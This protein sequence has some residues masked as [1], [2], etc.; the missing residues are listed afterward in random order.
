MT[1]LSRAVDDGLLRPVVT[2]VLAMDGAAQAHRRLARGGVA[3]RI[4]LDLS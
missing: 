1:A 2:E 3:G 4:V